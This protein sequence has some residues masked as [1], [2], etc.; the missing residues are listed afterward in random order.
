[1][2][3]VYD[4]RPTFKYGHQII[5]IVD[6]GACET[7][8]LPPPNQNTGE[9]GSMKAS[10][11]RI[12]LKLEAKNMDEPNIKPNEPQEPET[13]EEEVSTLGKLI[14]QLEGIV[15]MLKKEDNENDEP[16][17]EEAAEQPPLV[18]NVAAPTGAS[19]ADAVIASR[20][21]TTKYKKTT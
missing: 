20:A 3:I 14:K 6:E 18:N 13:N 10:K 2:S 15:K 1:M 17:Q 9:S 12:P 4:L 11:F 8:K 7:C 5:D 19:A 16:K 21:E